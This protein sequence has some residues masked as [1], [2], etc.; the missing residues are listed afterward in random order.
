M[1]HLKWGWREGKDRGE[2]ERK[3]E[4]VERELEQQ[5]R[6]ESP[7]TDSHKYSYEIFN[8]AAKSK[9]VRKNSLFNTWC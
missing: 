9:Q 3:G 6:I 2:R 1:S 7:E 5:N 4:R 8:K